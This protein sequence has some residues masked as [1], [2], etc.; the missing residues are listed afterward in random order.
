MFDFFS[1]LLNM[2]RNV[3]H[4]YR[5]WLGSKEVNSNYIYKH[6]HVTHTRT[7]MYLRDYLPKLFQG[8]APRDI[9]REQNTCTTLK[10][11]MKNVTTEK[12]SYAS[13]CERAFLVEIYERMWHVTLRSIKY[14]THHWKKDS[15]HANIGNWECLLKIQ[16][17]AQLEVGQ[18]LVLH[19]MNPKSFE[20]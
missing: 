4:F 19:D 6:M 9:H 11:E 14:A 1:D 15:S 8:A 20:N 17:S 18:V 10:C 7:L 5:I 3:F 16:C 12:Y 2:T 13:H